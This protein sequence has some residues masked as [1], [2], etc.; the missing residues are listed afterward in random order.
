MNATYCELHRRLNNEAAIK[1]LR[2]KRNSMERVDGKNQKT[3][4]KWALIDAIERWLERGAI[5][6]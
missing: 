6:G 1:Y 5:V 3:I 2:E 4:A